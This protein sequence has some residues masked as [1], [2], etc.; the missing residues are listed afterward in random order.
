MWLLEADKERAKKQLKKD[1]GKH[2]RAQ[3]ALSGKG[4]SR[5]TRRAILAVVLI[6]TGVQAIYFQRKFRQE[7]PTRH[8]FDTA[9]KE[10]YD[11][12]MA[13]PAR[14]IYLVDGYWGPAYIHAFLYATLQGKT[15]SEF[16]H[17]D[18]GKRPPPGAL[19]LSSEDK[20]TN[21]QSIFHREI[22]ML[23]RAL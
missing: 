10:V 15:T 14:P 5:Q 16:I 12:A 7:G 23:Y 4:F 17:L 6:L 9:Y 3:S 21:C 22:Y 2:K 13:Q 19:V 11:A 18:D 8:V 20:C 1:R